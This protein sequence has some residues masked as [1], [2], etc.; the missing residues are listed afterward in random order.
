M[1]YLK[2]KMI[3]RYT[4]INKM[5]QKIKK[6]EVFL[7]LTCHSGGVP[8][9]VVCLSLHGAVCRCQTQNHFVIGSKNGEAITVSGHSVHFLNRFGKFI[10]PSNRISEKFSLV[11]CFVDKFSTHIS[12]LSFRPLSIHCKQKFCERGPTK[13]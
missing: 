6:F 4:W 2:G 13:S 11:S 12:F 10:Q 1:K 7:S 9:S 3:H 5:N 8:L